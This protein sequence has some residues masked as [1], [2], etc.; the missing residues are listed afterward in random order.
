MIMFDEILERFGYDGIRDRGGKFDK[1]RSHTV[2]VVFDPG[3]V[4]SVFKKRHIQP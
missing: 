4:K 1:D 3:Q 2:W